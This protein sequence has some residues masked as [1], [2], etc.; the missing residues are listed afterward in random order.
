ISTGKIDELIAQSYEG[1]HQKMKEAVN[2]VA[3]VIQGLQKEL[4]RLTHASREGRLAE[5]GEKGQFKGAYAEVVGGVNEMLDAILLPIAEGNRVL[6]LIRGGNLRE[7]VELSCRGDHEKM[8]EAINGVHDW[9]SEL[10]VYITKIANGDMSGTA[11]R[12]SA[13]DQIFEWLVLL[14]NNISGLVGDV[15]MLSQAAVNGKVGLRADAAQHRGEYRRIVEGFNHT[16]DTVVEPLK[17]AAGQASAL[18]SSAEELT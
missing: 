5:R 17:I 12:A 7:K 6:G 11:T 8:K 10:V 15:N 1:D 9:L 16:L 13:D 4:Q 2:N 14:K 3:V 18:A